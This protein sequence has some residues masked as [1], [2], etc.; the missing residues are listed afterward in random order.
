LRTLKQAQTILFKLTT[1]ESASTEPLVSAMFRSNFT[2][3]SFLP[4]VSSHRG[5]SGI[6]LPQSHDK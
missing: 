5:V 6:N 1:L 3:S 4:L 2:A